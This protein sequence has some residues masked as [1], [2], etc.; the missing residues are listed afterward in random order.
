MNEYR[1]HVNQKY[2]QNFK[3]TRELHKWTVSHPHDFWPDLYNYLELVPPLPPTTTKAYDDLIPMSGIPPFFPGH[4]INYTENAA[5]SNPD[6]DAVALIGI[7]E[8]QDVNGSPD[9]VVTFKAFREKLREVASALKASGIKQGDRVAAIVATSVWAVV[10]FHAA[11][12]MGAIFTVISPDMGAQGCVTR[13]QQVQPSILFVDSHALFKGKAV[14]TAE[15]MREIVSQL[16]PRPQVFVIAIEDGQTHDFPSIKEFL[17]RARPSDSLVFTRVPFNYP[18]MICYSS[19]TTGQ[20]KCIVHQ[21]GFVLQLKKIAVVHNCIGPGDVV[22]Q[23]SN[24]SWVVFYGMCGQLTSGAT[25]VVYNGSPLFPDAKQ[26]LRICD[27]HKVSFLG[28]SP[29]LLLEMERSGAVPKR[30][31]DLS[32]LKTMHT[33]GA[34]LSIEQYRWLYRAF[35]PDVQVCN[36]AGG[37]ETGTPV[38][39]LDPSGPIHAGEMQI[40]GL[41]MDVDVADPVT[42]ESIAHTGEPGEM[43]IRQPFP[44]MPCFFWGDEGGKIY[45]AAYFERFDNMDVWAQHDWLRQNPKTGGYVMQGRSDGVL[46]KFESAKSRVVCEC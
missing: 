6:P 11:A 43:I 17:S 16:K 24:T 19:G 33:T 29:R 26:L 10:L 46:S 41:G 12:S 32:P 42:G 28:V 36:I 22:L 23:Y 35:P 39:S 45:K 27:R 13:L 15:K 18:L 38:I 2:K 31:F 4:T 9:E 30:D 40:E 34:P 20:P 7:R 44:S 3:T 14:S 37:T 21:H 1:Q 5:F 25:L 8:G